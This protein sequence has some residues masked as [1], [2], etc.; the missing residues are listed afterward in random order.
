MRMI[1]VT[2]VVIC[3]YA[4]L[5]IH[6]ENLSEQEKN[7]VGSF[8]IRDELPNFT[9]TTLDGSEVDMHAVAAENKIVLV[10]FW[11]TW[12]GPCRMEM[13][14]FERMYQDHGEDGFTILAV[15]VRESPEVV[16]AFIEDEGYTF[17][18]LLDEDGSLADSYGIRA[19]PTSLLV[20][21]DA[22]LE[23]SIIGYDS[24]IE[25]KVKWRLD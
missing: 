24:S 25:W 17:P 16:R 10:N 13:P 4:A 11:A 5:S 2:V 12:C 19:F 8:S 7:R 9:L 14:M 22:R 6:V 20:T 3:G 21:P 1:A 15:N 18:I 23:E